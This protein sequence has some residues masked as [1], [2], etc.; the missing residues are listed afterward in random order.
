MT[1]KN[2][3][4]WRAES[5]NKPAHYLENRIVYCA[6]CETRRSLAS[7]SGVL[8]CSVC[9]SEHWSHLSFVN[10]PAAQPYD[11]RTVQ[12]RQVVERTVEKLAT[13]VFFSPEVSLV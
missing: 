7:D 2:W 12:A 9:G 1:R 3:L 11:E 10:L 4:E 5:K 8:A 13:E 6:D